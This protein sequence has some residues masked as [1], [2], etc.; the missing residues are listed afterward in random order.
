MPDKTFDEIRVAGAAVAKTIERV[1]A[2]FLLFDDYPDMLICIAKRNGFFE[3]LSGNWEKCLGWTNEEL[4]SK[5]W[6]EFVHPDDK[7]ATEDATEMM[8]SREVIDFENRYR[9]RDGT[10]RRLQWKTTTFNGSGT[11]YCVARIT[12]TE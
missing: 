12:G 6:I 11:A 3:W 9:H 10:W 4:M 7:Q 8:V 1:K 5:P 2:F